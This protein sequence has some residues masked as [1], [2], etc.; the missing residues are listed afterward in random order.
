MR[1]GL[2]AVLLLMSVSVGCV[3]KPLLDPANEK[4]T[5]A[6]SKWQDVNLSETLISPAPIIIDTETSRSRHQ[7]FGDLHLAVPHSKSTSTPQTLAQL[8]YYRRLGFYL[9]AIGGVYSFIADSRGN[10][11][12]R[13]LGN[14]VWGLGWTCWLGFGAIVRADIRQL[15]DKHNEAIDANGHGSARS[16]YHANS[17]AILWRFGSF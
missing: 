4:D 3:N 1:A 13:T 2:L 10:V 9:G 17:W 12:G 11:R 14:A 15:M 6:K 5:L 7:S 16:D 8:D